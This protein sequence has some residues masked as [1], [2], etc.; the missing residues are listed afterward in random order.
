[1]NIYVLRHGLAE[2]RRRGV[3]DSARKLTDEGRRKIR[4]A[5]KAIDKLELSLD[6]ILTSPLPRAE[7]TAR[8]VAEH[9]GLEK[10]LKLCPALEP[11]TS[12]AQILHMIGS[13]KPAPERVMIVGHEPSLSRFVSSVIAGNEKAALDL[14]KGG[15]C[16]I[17]MQSLSRSRG[18]LEWLLAPGQ[19]KTIAKA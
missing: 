6:M 18:S 1:M 16:K 7:E 19:L 14:K 3:E 12:S 4:R 11:E 10:H 17:S 9:L 13:F 5:A 8:I 2:E 15:L